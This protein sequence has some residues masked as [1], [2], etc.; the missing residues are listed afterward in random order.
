MQR[1]M[2]AVS[3][4]GQRPAVASKWPSTAGTP[5]ASVSASTVS[6]TCKQRAELV[7]GMTPGLCNRGG[8]GMVEHGR[9]FL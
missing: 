4:E 2:R 7:C 3:S 1:A 5:A 8:G 6:G 9:G